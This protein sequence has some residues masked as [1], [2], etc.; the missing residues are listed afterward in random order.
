M[1]LG[2]RSGDDTAH[3]PRQTSRSW[4]GRSALESPLEICVT[5]QPPH[6]RF[7]ERTLDLVVISIRGVVKQAP[8][9]ISHTANPVPWLRTASSPA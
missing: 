3:H 4:S 1:P 6:A 7:G 2:L 9:L 8:S 5:H